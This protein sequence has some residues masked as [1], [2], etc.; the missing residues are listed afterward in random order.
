MRSK[1]IKVLISNLIA[2]SGFVYADGLMSAERDIVGVW[3]FDRIILDG[4]ERPPFNPDLIIEFNFREDG[5]DTLLWYRNNEKGFCE[6]DG[7]YA[8]DGE[9]LRDKVTWVNPQN[10]FDCSRDPDMQL[11]RETS[12]PTVLKNG[13]L[14]MTFQVDDQSLTYIWTRT[15]R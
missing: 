1:L 3:R 9:F 12:T 15:L 8:F 10:R 4:E 5:S 6:R 7:R 2:F 14:Y 13:E 11:G